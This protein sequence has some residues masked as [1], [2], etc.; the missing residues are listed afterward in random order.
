[1]ILAAGRGRSTIPPEGGMA[2]TIRPAHVYRKKLPTSSGASTNH[3]AGLKGLGR[4]G[5]EPTGPEKIQVGSGSPLGL[6]LS[7]TSTEELQ[8]RCTTFPK[9]QGEGERNPDDAA[10]NCGGALLFRRSVL[11]TVNGNLPPFPFRGGGGRTST[12]QAPGPRRPAWTAGT[13]RGTAGSWVTPP[14]NCA[15]IQKSPTLT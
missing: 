3:G 4:P 2:S 1:M 15:Q 6:R 8:N 12:K 5:S 10:Y 9:P 11:S 7:A 14:P 13:E